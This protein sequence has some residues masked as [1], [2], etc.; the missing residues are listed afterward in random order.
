MVLYVFNRCSYESYALINQYE[1]INIFKHVLKTYLGIR[2]INPEH[3][4]RKIE[5]MSNK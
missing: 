2:S 3:V 5:N 4:V 1:I